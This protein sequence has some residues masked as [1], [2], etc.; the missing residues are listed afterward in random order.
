MKRTLVLIVWALLPAIAAAQYRWV[1]VTMIV[2]FGSG[3][4]GVSSENRSIAEH[5]S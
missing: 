2:R 3:G 4:A 1:N 5:S